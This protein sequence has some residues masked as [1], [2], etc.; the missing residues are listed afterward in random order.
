MPRCLPGVENTPQISQDRSSACPVLYLTCVF[1]NHYSLSFF[2]QK[3]R[4]RSSFLCRKEP[5]QLR[6]LPIF[7]VCSTMQA[8]LQSCQQCCCVA[9][10]SST[11]EYL[12]K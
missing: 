3:I 11:P 7:S 9:L 10:N 2:I 4:S 12:G 5:T 1:R 8:A 6:S